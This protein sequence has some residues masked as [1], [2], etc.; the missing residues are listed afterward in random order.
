MTEEIVSRLNELL[1][2][3]RAGVETL[4]RLGKEAEEA[5]LKAAFERIGRDESWS[6]QGLSRYITHLGGTPS[7]RTGDFADKVMVLPTLEE[8]LRLL[9]RGQ[10][11]VV[12]RIDALL[13]L[14]L[15]PGLKDFL[16]DMRGLHVGN[17]RWCDEKIAQLGAQP[18]D[19]GA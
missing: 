7:S 2:A 6:C 3:E 19:R 15:D 9:S 16:S 12:K 17:I 11:W 13:A 8:R 18:V 5:D 4:A 14:D 1:E 10:A